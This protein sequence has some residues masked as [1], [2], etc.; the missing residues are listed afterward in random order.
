MN[1]LHLVLQNTPDNTV[2]ADDFIPKDED[3]ELPF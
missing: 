2:N 3:D 1:K